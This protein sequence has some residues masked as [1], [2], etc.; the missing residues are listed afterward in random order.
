[1]PETAA[2]DDPIAHASIDAASGRAPWRPARLRL[3]TTARIVTPMRVRYRRRRRNTAI[4]TAVTIVMNRCQSTNVLP[5]SNP[6]L[7]KKKSIERDSDVGFHRVTARPMR[8]NIT[9]RVT[10][11][12]TTS[13]LS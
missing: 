5:M 8:K 6:S 13:D 3:S 10:T 9:P 11:S 1:M 12:C 2:I 4:A 7:P